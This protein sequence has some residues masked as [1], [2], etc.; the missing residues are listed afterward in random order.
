MQGCS[1]LVWMCFSL[2]GTSGSQQIKVR[3]CQIKWMGIEIIHRRPN[4]YCLLRQVKWDIV[5]SRLMGSLPKWRQTASQKLSHVKIFRFINNLRTMKPNQQLWSFVVMQKS[6]SRA[7]CLKA[8][9]RLVPRKTEL[10]A[11]MLCVTSQ[12][13]QRVWAFLIVWEL[14]FASGH[15][16]AVLSK[17]L[18]IVDRR[19][20]C[21]DTTKGK[22]PN[23]SRSWMMSKSDATGCSL[24]C[25]KPWFTSRHLK[26]RKGRCSKSYG[27]FVP[28]SLSRTAKSAISRRR[29]LNSLPNHIYIMKGVCLNIKSEVTS[30]QKCDIE[31]SMPE[32]VA[33]IYLLQTE[34]F[35][36]LN[37]NWIAIEL[38]NH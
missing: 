27:S 6:N 19:C 14:H 4:S 10:P 2:I 17:W 12:P 34:P 26:R 25:S 3:Q 5:P 16:K 21:C 1:R 31:T 23:W 15:A 33:K 29:C 13:Q 9:P 37:V 32:F 18:Q 24:L 28:A 8:K 20:T 22:D 38:I 35:H 7:L 30:R 36:V 11:L